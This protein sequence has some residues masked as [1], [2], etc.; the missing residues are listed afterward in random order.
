MQPIEIARRAGEDKIHAILSELNTAQL[1]AVLKQAGL[2]T[3]VPPALAV[4]SAKR[5]HLAQRVAKAIQDGNEDAA[6]ELFYQWLLHRR[7]RML[8]DYLSALGVKHVNGE[9][10]ESF[11]KT[12]PADRLHQEARLLMTKYD[13]QDVAIYLFYLDHHQESRVYEEDRTLLKALEG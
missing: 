10:E 13:P 7:R 3:K 9:T 11:T 1:R 12:V 6:S 2:S 8:A 4:P 5:R